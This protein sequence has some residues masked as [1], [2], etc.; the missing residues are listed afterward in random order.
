MKQLVLHTH[1]D[2]VLVGAR[3]VR[4]VVL[5]VLEEHLVHVRGRILEELVATVE[6]DERDFAFAQDAQLVRLLHQA[7]LPLGE[8]NLKH[9]K[10]VKWFVKANS[11]PWSRMILINPYF[12]GH[13]VNVNRKL[14]KLESKS[15]L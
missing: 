2:D 15:I 6:D 12:D 4:L 5:G 13:P 11:F 1:L 14:G 3:L 10:L 8:G 7:E 9:E